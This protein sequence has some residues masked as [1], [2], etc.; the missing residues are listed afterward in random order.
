MLAPDYSK[1]YYFVLGVKTSA[2]A[3]VLKRAYHNLAKKYH[4]DLHG[5]GQRQ[6]AEEI[7]KEINEAYEI[8]S[9]PVKRASYDDYRNTG[10]KPQQPKPRAAARAKPAAGYSD[11]ERRIYARFEKMAREAMEQGNDF[12]P[13]LLA[14]Y[15]RNLL[16]LQTFLGVAGLWLV[17]KFLKFA[18][19][20]WR[21]RI[22]LLL[23]IG[24]TFLAAYLLKKF[25]DYVKE[26]YPES[27]TEIMISSL[28]LLLVA[29]TLFFGY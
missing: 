13:A 9:D 17:F 4:P 19:P 20:D 26:T 21:S 10:A 7:F 28:V 24:G 14:T 5:G 3:E 29:G 11:E 8:L 27:H 1:D 25:S 16:I 18:F 23:K 12:P 2:S 6:A 22:I 15:R